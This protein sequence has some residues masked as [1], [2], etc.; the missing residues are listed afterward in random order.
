MAKN[1]LITDA[2]LAQAVQ[3][4]LGNISY[5]KFYE[6]IFTESDWTESD[7]QYTITIPNTEHG[8]PDVNVI[9]MLKLTD[10]GYVMTHGIFDNIDYTVTINTNNNILI[11]TETVFS[12]KFVMMC[13]Q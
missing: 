12:G 6:K 11:T 2:E 13:N 7:G 3:D 9:N 10:A 8:L 4:A 1:R 5:S